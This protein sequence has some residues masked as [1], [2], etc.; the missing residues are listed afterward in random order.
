MLPNDIEQ[1][2]L[3]YVDDLILMDEFCNTRQYQL[4]VNKKK[5]CDTIHHWDLER[6]LYH[7]LVEV[8]IFSVMANSIAGRYK[9]LLHYIRQLAY[10]THALSDEYLGSKGK[11]KQ[12][13]LKQC[14]FLFQYGQTILPA[15]FKAVCLYFFNTQLSMMR[16]GHVTFGILIPLGF[17]ALNVNPFIDPMDFATGHFMRTTLINCDG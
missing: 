8:E 3:R 11:Q 1:I 6:R 13:K 2:I 17:F 4:V 7:P 9:T 15:D 10:K 5:E 16:P 14:L 12:H